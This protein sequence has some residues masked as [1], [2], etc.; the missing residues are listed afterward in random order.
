MVM[1][2]S[3]SVQTAGIQNQSITSK[4]SETVKIDMSF[5]QAEFDSGLRLCGTK[6]R[7]HQH[8]QYYTITKYQDLNR[9]LGLLTG[10]TED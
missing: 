3:I 8:I 2:I 6:K 4:E 9:L 5:D 1:G 10:I 7:L